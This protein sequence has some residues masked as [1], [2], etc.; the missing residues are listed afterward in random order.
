MSSTDYL[1]MDSR[2]NKNI[3]LCEAGGIFQHAKNNTNRPVY[4]S[5]VIIHSRNQYDFN[6][7]LHFLEK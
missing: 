5:D 6:L 4:Y 2:P 3:T 7:Y 1:R